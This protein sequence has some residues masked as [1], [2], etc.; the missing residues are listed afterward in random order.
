MGGSVVQWSS[1]SPNTRK[2]LGSKPGGTFNFMQSSHLTALLLIN[3]IV[4][5][6]SPVA[7]LPG[8]YESTVAFCFSLFRKTTVSAQTFF[9][10]KC[11]LN[12]FCSVVVITFASH[13]KGPGFETRQN[14]LLIDSIFCAMKQVSP[15][16]IGTFSN[17]AVA[18]KT[19][20]YP[21]PSALP[22]VPTTVEN[23]CRG[24]WKF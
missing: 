23:V 24:A 9:C 8:H 1:R 2:V 17:H 21:I 11:N 20:T 10:T 14:L 19:Q 13:A 22:K 16:L 6:C 3:S 15:V 12:W 5:N 7:S 18:N 4:S